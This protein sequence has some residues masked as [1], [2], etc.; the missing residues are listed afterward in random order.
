[1]IR[2]ARIRIAAAAASAAAALTLAAC[3]GGAQASGPT[4]VPAPSFAG[5]GDQPSAAPNVPQP[6]AT[7]PSGPTSTT[8]RSSDDPAVVAT[9][10]RAPD[11]IVIMP[12]GSALV[13]ERGGRIVAVQPQPHQPVRTVRTLTGL[14]TAG[15]GGLLDLALSPNYAQDSLIYAYVTTG[16][17]NRLVDFTL[18]GPVTPVFTGIPKGATGNTGRIVVNADGTLSIGTSDA[19]RPSSAQSRTSLAGKV[20]RLSDIGSAATGNPNPG[21]AAFASGLSG[22][23]GLCLDTQHDVLFAVQPKGLGGKSTVVVVRAGADYGWPTS[24]ATSAKAIA[25]IPAPFATPGGCAVQADALYVTSLDGKTLL[26][27]PLTVSGSSV[28]VGSFAG[29]LPGRYGRLQTV[30]A[31]PDGALWLTT[32]NRAGNGKPIADD[33]RVLR[34]QAPAGGGSYPG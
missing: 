20:L 10:L 17:D 13:G 16:T 28:K 4:W 27:A 3:G 11:A 8:P 34:I 15:D 29:Y 22:V 23:A 30:V 24:S 25:T 19:A 14:D 26:G 2:G 6:G 7:G 1:M 33:E 31:A 12:D 32:A 9:N 21:S 18:T 5:E